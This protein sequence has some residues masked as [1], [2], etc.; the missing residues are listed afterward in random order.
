MNT[1]THS[2]NSLGQGVCLTDTHTLGQTPYKGLS[3][4]ECGSVDAPDSDK[5]E[6]RPS[7]GKRTPAHAPA[8]GSVQSARR[9]PLE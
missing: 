5:N 8:A 6:K 4:S 7:G 9:P 3:V 1:R 2:D